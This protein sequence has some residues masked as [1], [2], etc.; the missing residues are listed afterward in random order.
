[1]NILSVLAFRIDDI[2][3]HALDDRDVVAT[4][5]T[6]GQIVLGL[7]GVPLEDREVPDVDLF[8]FLKALGEVRMHAQP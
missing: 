7:R 3:R 1:M 8:I 5:E 6:R 2:P 4:L